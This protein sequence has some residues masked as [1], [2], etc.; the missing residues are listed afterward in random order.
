MEAA[1]IETQSARLDY[2]LS[3]CDVGNAALPPVPAKSIGHRLMAVSGLPRRFATDNYDLKTQVNLF[4][5]V[6]SYQAYLAR[7]SRARFQVKLHN[8]APRKKR[9]NEAK[10]M[11]VFCTYCSFTSFS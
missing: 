2:Q 3:K 10:A 5:P 9:L 11:L 8:K 6:G 1:S 7:C 4:A